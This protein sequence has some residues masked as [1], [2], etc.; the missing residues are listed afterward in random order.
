[1]VL[2]QSLSAHARISAATFPPPDAVSGRVPLVF[3]WLEGERLRDAPATRN[4]GTRAGPRLT[5]YS[6]RLSQPPGERGAAML[7]YLLTVE[8]GRCLDEFAAE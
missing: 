2:P 3:E 5:L 4:K 8:S 1:M 7:V 6:W